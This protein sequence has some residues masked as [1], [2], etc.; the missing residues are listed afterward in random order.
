MGFLLLALLLGGLSGEGS[1]ALQGGKPRFAGRDPFALLGSHRLELG[2]DGTP[3]VTVG[4]AKG[5]EE[6]EILFPEGAILH[7]PDGGRREAPRGARWTFSIEKGVP[8]KRRYWVQVGQFRF[9]DREEL[10][11]AKAQWE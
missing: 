11:R 5:E 4:I 8:A 3:L 7:L 6:V 10:Q 9:E 2:D 1:A